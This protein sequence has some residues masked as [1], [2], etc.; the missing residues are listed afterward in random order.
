[1]NVA[2]NDYAKGLS[3]V[4]DLAHKIEETKE[5]WPTDHD[6][7]RSAEWLGRMVG[8]LAGPGKQSDLAAQIEKL[9][10][11]VDR[12]LTYERKAAYERG[13]KFVTGRQESLK[14]LLA[15]PTHEVLDEL[16][17]KRQEILEAARAADAEVKQLEDDLRE[18]KKPHDKQMAELNHEIRLAAQK[19]K[20]AQRDIPEA[21]EAVETF[22]VP[23]VYAQMRTTTRY[24]VPYATT[25]SENAQEK[26]SRE[27][28]LASAKQKLQQVHAS[29]DQAR[30]EMSDLKSQKEQAD[31][32]YRKA[33]AEK[34]PLLSAARRK[35]QDLAARARDSEQGA[36][37]PE[38]LKT[39][40]TAL[41]TYVPL[42]PEIE[43]SRLLATLKTSG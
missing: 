13:R 4:L 28:Q 24:R 41:E 2:K 3:A 1:V 16:K 35:A 42:D 14:T 37:T 34:R 38:K 25:R 17:Q 43:K 19:S 36:L 7:M 21:E 30:Q 9:E 10:A 12:L 39:R 22:S 40:V 8:F 23:Q 26:K 15:R 27:T 18:I 20:K 32:D 5:T 6:R 33:A 31:A 11:E 29:Y